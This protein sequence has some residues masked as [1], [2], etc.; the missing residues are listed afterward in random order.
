M[1]LFQPCNV[2][3]ALT[4]TIHETTSDPSG[5]FDIRNNQRVYGVSH[6]ASQSTSLRPSVMSAY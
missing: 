1:L 2:K 4:M 5:L 3:A 6:D